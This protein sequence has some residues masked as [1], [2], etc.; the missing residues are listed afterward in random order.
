LPLVQSL[1]PSGDT[2]L[3]QNIVE[4]DPVLTRFDDVINQLEQ[5]VRHHARRGN[6]LK[7]SSDP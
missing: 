7:Y 3:G 1:E 2:T 4:F 5:R 6:A